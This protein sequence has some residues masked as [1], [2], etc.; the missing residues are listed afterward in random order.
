MDNRYYLTHSLI[1]LFT[2]SA[3]ACNLWI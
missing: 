1:H 2:I 3:F